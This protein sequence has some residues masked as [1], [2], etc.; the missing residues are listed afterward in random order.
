MFGVPINHSFRSSSLE[1]IPSL[2]GSQ[3]TK[4]PITGHNYNE[5]GMLNLDSSLLGSSPHLQGYLL[6]SQAMGQQS[7][8]EYFQ[9]GLGDDI[10]FKPSSNFTDFNTGLDGHHQLM[11]AGQFGGINGGLFGSSDSAFLDM[12]LSSWKHLHLFSS[13]PSPLSPL[14]PTL[15]LLYFLTVCHSIF[16]TIHCQLTIHFFLF[17]FYL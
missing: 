6:D 9:S 11:E 13:S 4:A 5:L 1:V 14:H 3:E 10:S 12:N 8:Y 7:S 2:D 15:T 17:S 16:K